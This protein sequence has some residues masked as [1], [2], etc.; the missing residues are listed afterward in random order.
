MGEYSKFISEKRRSVPTP[1]NLVEDSKCVFGTFDKEFETMDFLDIKNPTE[2][3]DF[4][5]P[6]RLTLWEATEVL[7]KE[8]YML[9]A[10]CNMGLLGVALTLFYDQRTRKIY[11]W[12]ET[13]TPAEAVISPNLINGSVTHAQRKKFRIHYVNNFQD[14]RADVDGFFEGKD[15]TIDY[16]V[17]LT[18][19]SKPSVVS[20]PFANPAFPLSILPAL[21]EWHWI[22]VP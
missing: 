16:N 20:I 14:G 22:M 21:Q 19:I 17:E 9:T 15:G 7:L 10:V 12:Q 11:K 3:P 4:L 8:G 2:A 5:K 1:K 6:I 13:L 18:R